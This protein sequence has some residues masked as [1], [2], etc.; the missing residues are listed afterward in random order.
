MADMSDTFE[1]LSTAIGAR[2]K[3]QR[4]LG[5]GGMAKVYLAQDLKYQRAVAVKVLLPELA[6]SVG[7]A[8]G[9]RDVAAAQVHWVLGQN[10]FG[11]TFV[12]GVGARSPMRPHHD[13]ARVTGSAPLGAVVGGPSSLMVREH[14]GLAPPGH[15]ATEF[16]A[17]STR[18][19][20][21]Q[22]SPDDFVVN[23]PAIDF[24]PALLY[25]IAALGEAG[26]RRSP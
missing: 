4:L 11:V 1:K 8:S 24:T 9:C 15:H 23:E 18:E 5:Q 12:S 14:S 13:L 26:S 21:Y 2:Y 10:P 6:E 16:A 3:L 20:F 19:L 22:D 17:F 7:A 25:A